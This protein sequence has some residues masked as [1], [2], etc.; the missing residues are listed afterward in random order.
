M[1][2]A[3]IRQ[4]FLDF[5]AAK[6]HRIVPSASLLPTAP[7]LLFTNAG[8][9]PFV[10][11]FLGEREAPQPR[12]ADT[13]KCIRAGGKHN[14]LDDVGLDTYHQT[15]FEMLG[16]WSFG[17][18]FKQ[19]AIEWA[20]ELLT[21]VWKFPRERL[22]VT[23]YQPGEG[24]PAEFDQ[25]AHD[26]WARVLRASGLNPDERILTGGK[27]DNFWM[28]GDTGPCGPCSEIHIDLT[29]AGDTG[30]RLVNADSPYCIE[31]WNLVF[32][33][34]NADEDGR[35]TPLRNRHV[36]TGMG[37]ERVAGIIAT[38]DG[39]TDFSRPPSNYNCDL[40][41]PIFNRVSELCGHSYRATLPADP[42]RPSDAEML[43]IAFRVVADHI[44]TLCCAIADGILPGNEGRN[45][46][47]RRILRRAVLYGRRLQLP[48][49]F[50]TQLVEP[51]IAVLGDVFP[52]LRRQQAVIRKVIASEEAAFE[53]T[54]ERGLLMLDKLFDAGP[55]VISGEDAFTLYDTHGFPLDLTQIIAAEKGVAVDTAG[56]NRAME[57]QRARARAA[58]QSSVIRVSE[59]EEDGMPTVFIGFEP[60]NLRGTVSTVAN[61]LSDGENHYVILDK[62][63]CYAEMG[64]QVG[65]RG[66][67]AIDGKVYPISNT[68][69]DPAGHVLHRIDAPANA[70][71]IDRE[72]RVDV[73]LPHRKAVQ[74]HH[75]ATHILHWALRSVLGT[76]VRQAGSFVGQDRLRF[77]F[78]HFEQISP[79]QLRQIE[80]LCMEKILENDPVA[81]YEVPFDDKPDDVI[82]FFGEKYGDVVRVVDIGGWS[83][84]LCGGTH[85]CATG[86]IG[87]FKIV[88]ESAIAAGTRRI[89]A[90]CG[91]AAAELVERRFAVLAGLAHTF[92]ARPEE[93]PERVGELQHRLAE[94]ERAVK[95]F[96]AA[97]QA[98][99]AAGLRDEV[100]DIDGLKVL[101]RPMQAGNPNDLRNLAARTFKEAGADLLVTG[102]AFGDKVT[103]LAIAS[104][105]AVARGH[106]AGDIIRALTA[107]LGGKGGGKP[108][109]AMGGG[110]KPGRLQPALADWRKSLSAR[111]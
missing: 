76:H 31:L 93:V 67:L 103:V 17:D 32:I 104:E 84:E 18:Y 43:D 1:T 27:K 101:A 20:W 73:D 58:R 60:D 61:V 88:A 99:Q 22:Y 78:S 28:M 111:S 15:F 102:C 35:F 30:G 19:E 26:N 85:V 36:D 74:R 16:N 107:Q 92:A 69:R 64:G 100:L 49:G 37:F 90:V 86:E 40:F 50:F 44:R 56:F 48:D 42:R 47:L 80:R 3:E 108:D 87:L 65:D 66:T 109:F 12:V 81:W 97:A 8:M 23:V 11:Y 82:A 63:P 79:D 10:P 98:S 4:S 54:I 96:K 52:E 53:R 9:N 105:A 110:T 59:E 94:A 71:L 70:E 21:E 46:V 41:T 75:S 77:D 14:D 95:A 38:T 6:G 33:Q 25:E 13:Q 39:F 51:V 7:N 91:E 106:K 34:F 83:R 5:F 55:E 24:D 45:Y 2:S 62:T 29:P 57:A 72:V 68:T 89:E